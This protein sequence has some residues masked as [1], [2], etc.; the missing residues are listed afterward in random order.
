MTYKYS[1]SANARS[2]KP[3]QI[4]KVEKYNAEAL[5][6]SVKPDTNVSKVLPTA[7]EFSLKS[8][9]NIKPICNHIQKDQ[10]TEG[11][12]KAEGTLLSNN[13]AQFKVG[14]QCDKDYIYSYFQEEGKELVST[15]QASYD[16]AVNDF[17]SHLASPT[18]ML[19]A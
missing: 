16:A 17:L 14:I 9:N 11:F 19:E 4:F 1:F 18:L 13:E 12:F 5:R 15:T 2:H 3:N 8:L 7:A 6:F 10:L